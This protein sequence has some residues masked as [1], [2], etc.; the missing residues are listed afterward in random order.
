[1]AGGW[2][3]HVEVVGSFW[4]GARPDEIQELLTQAAA[5][6]WEPVELAP[7]QNSSRMMIILRR[8]AARDRRTARERTWP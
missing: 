1:V 4:R 5:E 2:E 7:I 3:Y 6:D 8:P